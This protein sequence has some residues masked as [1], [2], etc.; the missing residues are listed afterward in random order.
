MTPCMYVQLANAAQFAVQVNDPLS[1]GAS[2][3][4]DPTKPTAGDIRSDSGTLAKAFFDEA[5]RTPAD[6]PPP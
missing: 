2:Y 3:D 4:G 6:A 5:D 1:R